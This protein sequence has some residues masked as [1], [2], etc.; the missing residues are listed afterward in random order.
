MK[1]D[2]D[3]HTY[4]MNDLL[5]NIPG[6][7]SRAMFGGWGIYQKRIIFAIIAD[8]GLYFKVDETNKKDFEE[9]DMRP[10]MYTMPNGKQMAMAYWQLPEEI[11]ENSEELEVWVSKSVEVSLRGKKS[12]PKSKQ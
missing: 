5:A 4:I 7:T 11:M 3:F 9:C 12:K 8:G 1:K 6:V 2:A 10:F